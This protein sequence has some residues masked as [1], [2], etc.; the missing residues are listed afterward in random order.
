LA[1]SA[2]HRPFDDFWRRGIL[3]DNKVGINDTA[4]Y[5]F[6]NLPMENFHKIEIVP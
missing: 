4:L 1:F 2:R 5:C 3:A 6:G